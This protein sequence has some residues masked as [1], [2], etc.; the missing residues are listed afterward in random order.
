MFTIRAAPRFASLRST[1]I[2]TRAYSPDVRPEGTTGSS[3]GFSQ[4]EQAEEGQYVKKREAEKLKAAKKKLEEAQAEFVSYPREAVPYS[5]VVDPIRTNSQRK[6]R[7]NAGNPDEGREPSS[8][9]SPPTFK[10]GSPRPFAPCPTP[11]RVTYNKDPGRI[12]VPPWIQELG[13]GWALATTRRAE[14]VFFHGK[15]LRSTL[16]SD[17]SIGYSQWSVSCIL[18][19]H[20][21]T[22]FT[23]PKK[24]RKKAKPEPTPAPSHYP[25]PRPYLALAPSPVVYAPALPMASSSQTQLILPS[26]YVRSQQTFPAASSS[27]SANVVPTSLSGVGTR[28]GYAAGLLAPPSIMPGGTSPSPVVPLQAT[29]RRSAERIGPAGRIR[30]A[31]VNV[32]TTSL[33]QLG[34]ILESDPLTDGAENP[35]PQAR[36]RRRIV[37]GETGGLTRRPTVT[38]REEGR[39]VGLSRSASMRRT[40]VWD[41]LPESADPPPPFPFPTSST[42]RLP[43][44]F[45]TSTSPS[46]P[47]SLERPLSPPPTFE[48]AISQPL[49]LIETGQSTPRARPTLIITQSSTP[50]VSRPLTPSPISPASTQFASAPTS[51][52]ETVVPEEEGGTEEERADRRMWNA[53]L[54]AGY[55]LGERVR[56]EIER[57]KKREEEGRR[58]SNDALKSNNGEITTSPVADVPTGM[59]PSRSEPLAENTLPLAPPPEPSLLPEISLQQT[60]TP[61]GT[62]AVATSPRPLLVDQAISPSSLAKVASPSPTV[63]AE[64]PL[65]SPKPDIRFPSAKVKQSPLLSDSAITD[66]T[67]EAKVSPPPLPAKVIPALAKPK[68]ASTTST[69]IVTTPV[70]QIEVAPLETGPNISPSSSRAGVSPPQ[71]P[72]VTPVL[73]A[74]VEQPVPRF[75]PQEVLIPDYSTRERHSMLPEPGTEIQLHPARMAVP[76][77]VPKHDGDSILRLAPTQVRET[78]EPPTPPSPVGQNELAVKQPDS[79][80]SSRG[81]TVPM[82]ISQNTSSGSPT[83]DQPKSSLKKPLFGSSTSASSVFQSKRASVPNLEEVVKTKP[84]FG[85]RASASEVPHATTSLGSKPEAP[86]PLLPS[87]EAALKRRELGVRRTEVPPPPPWPPRVKRN[88]TPTVAAPSGPLIDFT[89]S[90]AEIEI[91][92]EMPSLASSISELLRLLDLEGENR[93]PVAESSK[94]AVER[95]GAESSKQAAERASRVATPQAQTRR[96]IPPPPPDLQTPKNVVSSSATSPIIPLQSNPPPV[97]SLRLK[98]PTLPTRRPPPPPPA[99]PVNVRANSGLST[100]SMES[101]TPLPPPPPPVWRRSPRINLTAKPRGPRPAPPPIP[102]RPWTRVVVGV[103]DENDRTSSEIN[104]PASPEFP[105]S[106]HS[107]SIEGQREVVEYTDLDVLVSRLEGSGREYEVGGKD[108]LCVEIDEI[109]TSR[110]IPRSRTSWALRNRYRRHRQSPRCFLDPSRSIRNGRQRRAK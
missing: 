48:Q 36:R 80:V 22:D 49:P 81:Q 91:H 70:A 38:S 57:K 11:R 85:H 32:S 79:P 23:A 73:A 83:P 17:K 67:G 75:H 106:Q 34:Q 53:D 59:P 33:G 7:S 2:L 45:A 84:I 19:V 64:V 88:P 56:R 93:V 1:P 24:A 86:A 42:S 4:R 43:P 31:Q 61:I 10:T 74:A 99:P 68:I 94:Q 65:P 82:L 55:G 47:P 96:R 6:R 14:S 63:N 16:T 60:V 30:T 28:G 69:A 109:A 44:G 110:A 105:H 107:R 92:P 103:D 52:T 62:E 20:S 9:P 104:R 35:Q 8:G 29:R 97:L 78:A 13:G 37:R 87:R 102:P 101:S 58:E 25:V 39:A 15:E 95:M 76:E 108:D 71:L 89:E 40:N 51:P 3:K 50:S 98:P 54:L 27:S 21:L 100:S 46:S 5:D 12:R 18:A 72:P 26:S 66:Q 77:T 90:E 41:D